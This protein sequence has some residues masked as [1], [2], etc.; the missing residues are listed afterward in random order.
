MQR[1]ISASEE[2]RTSIDL[3]PM[4]DVVFIMLIF[5]VVTAAF[6]RES[7][8][9]VALAG[10]TRGLPTDVASISV[11]VGRSGDFSVNGRALSRGNLLPYLYAVRS[12][13]PEAGFGLVLEQGSQVVDAV[14]AADAGR[15]LGF[16]VIPV[17]GPD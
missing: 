9:P 17:S 1:F 11:T 3:T 12:V 2:E 5:F 8:L 7:G 13:N 14:H 15:Q 16:E 10:E 4:L 6:L